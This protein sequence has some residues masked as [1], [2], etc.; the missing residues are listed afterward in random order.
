MLVYDVGVV[1]FI[2]FFRHFQ[3]NHEAVTVAKFFTIH[4][5]LEKVAIFNAPT[6]RSVSL[7]LLKE[8]SSS[9][10]AELPVSG[11]LRELRVFGKVNE[12]VFH[13]R[14]FD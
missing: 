13:T 1:T 2:E 4:D 7:R 10:P 3:I 6:N 11:T 12:R 5:T 14:D 8:S 9:F